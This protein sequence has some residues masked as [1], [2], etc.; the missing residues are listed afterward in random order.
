MELPYGELQAHNLWNSHM[1]QVMSTPCQ[2]FTVPRFVFQ[3]REEKDLWPV[4]RQL[5]A[6]EPA[7][8]VRRASNR[9]SWPE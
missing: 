1:T 2:I 8:G 4:R 9:R 7:L 5:L 6:A 3:I